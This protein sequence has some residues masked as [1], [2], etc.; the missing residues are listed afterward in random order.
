MDIQFHGA[1]CITLTTKQARITV[2]DNIASLGGKT[3]SKAGDVALFTG[4]HGDP[5]TAAKITID[6]PGEYEV[7]GVSIYGIPA[8]AHID[9]ASQRSATIFKLVVDDLRILVVGH[10]YPEFSDTQLEAIGTVDVMIVPVG[11]SG[12]TL[13]SLGALKVVK[14]IEPKLVI[15]THFED[16]DL[17]FPVPQ[18]PL[19]EAIK[20]FGLESKEVGS[21]L[22]LKYSEL[23][24]TMQIAVLNRV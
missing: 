17:E 5:V 8:R 7:S 16:A 13:D 15:P 12:Y 3:A 10:I 23:E 4:A 14:K 19:E 2:D 9:E 1:N 18:H 21:K 20:T 6:Q 22:K 11:G 24:D